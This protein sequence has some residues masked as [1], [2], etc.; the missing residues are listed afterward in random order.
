MKEK[1]VQTPDQIA[2]AALRRFGFSV[3]WSVQRFLKGAAALAGHS[4]YNPRQDF[5]ALKGKGRIKAEAR[6]LAQRAGQE[7]DK[8][9]YQEARANIESLCDQA[10]IDYPESD[11]GTQPERLRTEA[12]E[13]WGR[14]IRVAN[15]R[16]FERLAMQEKAFTH[17]CSDTMAEARRAQRKENEEL[18]KRVFCLSNEGDSLALSEIAKGNNSNPAVR[19]AE[20]MTRIRGFED[21][22]K[23]R[24]YPAD[25]YTIT[26]PSKM[27]RNKGA[28]WNGFTPKQVQE[29]FG[30]CWAKTR[31]K[32]GRM[33]ITPFG[34]RVAEPHKDGCPHWHMLLWF[35]TVADLKRARQVVLDYFLAEDGREPGA[36]E[37]RV[38]FKLM[39]ASK[40]GATGYIAKYICKN[41][42]GKFIDSQGQENTFS[43]AR[44]DEDGYMR[45]TGIDSAT[46]AARV[47]AWAAC[48]G[49]RQ[50]QQIG[51]G[52][53]G[54]W[55][56]LRRLQEAPAGLEDI[57]L[58][59]GVK[60][61]ENH[62]PRWDLFTEKTWSPRG[63]VGPVR[64]VKPWHET[65][66]DLMQQAADEAGGADK[67]TDEAL[68]LCCNKW[69]EPTVR[70]PKGVSLGSLQVKTR[71]K[72]WVVVLRAALD[73]RD[74]P[75]HKARTAEL[76]AMLTRGGRK[77]SIQEVA[78]AVS[79]A[80]LTGQLA[81][82]GPDLL[83]LAFQRGAQPPD[84]E[85][86]K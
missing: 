39:D 15:K 48:W 14:K 22:A 75:I 24:G 1:A 2:S 32:L 29:Y 64:P 20:L 45:E 55:R 3:V 46:A 76:D 33:G 79:L 58:A 16:E 30:A 40:G 8:A 34:F 31:A 42:D 12:P 51:G 53:V 52:K 65:S 38:R 26:A 11:H 44:P 78:R 13:W 77:L 56:E 68:L 83:F 21:Y 7:W 47:D 82:R 41:V 19:R 43:D 72:K 6:E 50:F 25:F 81:G 66:I 84:S 71:F 10:G 69:Q 67:V 37:N 62:K 28:K 54:V 9:D 57:R 36:A 86:C 23:A 70:K 59:C 49:I 5:I 60:G 27:H 73:A 17:Y 85:R 63:F 4:H 61:D 74:N 18:L 80:R 35:E